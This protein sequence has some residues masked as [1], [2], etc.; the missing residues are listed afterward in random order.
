MGV[1]FNN[2]RSQHLGRCLRSSTSTSEGVV[3]QMLWPHCWCYVPVLGLAT[4]HT[5]PAGAGWVQQLMPGLLQ[6]VTLAGRCSMDLPSVPCL[7]ASTRL[8]RG[9][10]KQKTNLS[11]WFIN[12]MQAEHCTTILVSDTAEPLVLLWLDPRVSDNELYSQIESTCYFKTCISIFTGW[13]QQC[14]QLLLFYFQKDF[15]NFECRNIIGKQ[16]YRANGLA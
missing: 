7:E 2:Q 4:T 15:C 12:P 8:C 3:D 11:I 10:N 1:P 14:A 9:K 6:F 5:S 16:K 13:A